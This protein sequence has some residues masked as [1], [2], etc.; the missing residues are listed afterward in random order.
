MKK[1]LFTLAAACAAFI[2]INTAS[3]HLD[4]EGFYVGAAGS[5]D[6]QRDASFN[7]P[8]LGPGTKT[9]VAFNTGGNASLFA[10][11]TWEEWSLELEG[12]F[13]HNSID[14][15]KTVAADTDSFNIGDHGRVWSI[16]ANGYY[17]F[18]LEN[19]FSLYVG[20]GVGVGFYSLEIDAFTD[21][22]VAVSKVDDK[23]TE[24]AWQATGGAS[25]ELSDQVSL[26][27]GYRFF[28]TT[29][30]ADFSITAGGTAYTTS[31]S[32]FPYFHSIEA[33][34]LIRL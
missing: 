29:K 32:E 20:A 2:G 25:Y 1:N 13:R 7:T 19:C 26:F 17:D 5:V 31:W 23:S 18:P 3:A 33:G 9:E 30:P 16:M 4:W 28:A 10:G 6:W 8:T 11:Y 24:F 22:G 27:A 34:L 15:V 12:G 21:D 14:T